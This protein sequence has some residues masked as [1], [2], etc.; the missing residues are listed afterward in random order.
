MYGLFTI[1]TESILHLKKSIEVLQQD[2][3][4]LKVSHTEEMSQLKKEKR[5]E[6]EVERQRL[7]NQIWEVT[8]LKQEASAKVR[9]I[10]TVINS[11]TV[12]LKFPLRTLA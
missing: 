1:F 9:S 4:N 5:E 2:I 6:L 11:T 10:I 3:S 12:I 7:L 8:K